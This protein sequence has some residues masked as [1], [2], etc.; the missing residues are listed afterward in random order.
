MNAKKLENVYQFH[1]LLEGT[2]PQVWR[3][4][5]VP[6]NYTMWDL[7]VAIQDA[8]GWSDCHLHE[9]R[10]IEKRP[11]KVVRIGIPDDYGYGNEAMAG[12]EQNI[13]D[14]FLLEKQPMMNYEYDFGDG[15]DH[16]IILEKI[17]VKTKGTKY[18]SCIDGKNACPFE[19]S[20][21]IYG[22][23]NKIDILKNPEHERY[24]EVKDWM[25]DEVNLT[26]FDCKNVVFDNPKKR[27]KDM[28][29]YK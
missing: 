21:G 15:W 4:I 29:N 1:I 13:D 8:M 23:Y 11:G 24:D 9:F 22:F 19:D 16:K 25:G 6:E 27:L 18:P 14:W 20:G 12:W 3:R 17:I 7:H 10:T 2:K 26:D 28:L 5:Q